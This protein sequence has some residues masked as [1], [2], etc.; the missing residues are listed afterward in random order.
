MKINRVLI[1]VLL[2]FTGVTGAQTKI[3]GTISD[4]ETG[5]PISGVRVRFN[6]DIQT[7]S[8]KDGKFCMSLPKNAKK[9]DS[10]CFYISGYNPLQTPVG[11][12]KSRGNIVK[13]SI[14]TTNLDIVSIQDYTKAEALIKEVVRR[15]S[16]N[17]PTDATLSTFFCHNTNFINNTLC[18][19]EEGLDRVEHSGYAETRKKNIP[20]IGTPLIH[21]LLVYNT[22]SYNTVIRADELSDFRPIIEKHISS[23][24]LFDVVKTLSPLIFF[25][26]GT[27]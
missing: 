16:Q 25:Q 4:K 7:F 18:C 27:S 12:F 26:Y 14:L 13:M 11:D 10:V 6:P 8:D 17:Y 19:F 5:M 20:A 2:C 24:E 3:S 9:N 21:Q 1:V 15:R 23:F 22:D